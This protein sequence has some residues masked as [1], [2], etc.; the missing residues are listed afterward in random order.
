M[1]LNA[2]CLTVDRFM[3]VSCQQLLSVEHI[4]GESCSKHTMMITIILLVISYRAAL[5]NK[6]CHQVHDHNTSLGLETANT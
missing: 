1:P 6:Y 2:A 3:T 4:T 5:Y